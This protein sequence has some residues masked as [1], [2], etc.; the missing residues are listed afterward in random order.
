MR[1][2]ATKKF[3]LSIVDVRLWNTVTSCRIALPWLLRSEL[4]PRLQDPK[5]LINIQNHPHYFSL[6]RWIFSCIVF[7]DHLARIVLEY[8]SRKTVF[9]GIWVL[10]LKC[11]TAK[12]LLLFST[13][14]LRWFPVHE[15]AFSHK[16]LIRCYTIIIFHWGDI[17]LL[18][19]SQRRSAFFCSL[20]TPTAMCSQMG[21]QRG[22]CWRCMWRYYWWVFFWL[23]YFVVPGHLCW[24]VICQWSHSILK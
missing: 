12:F 16:Y 20:W 13:S 6:Y 11:F 1:E 10:M 17:K 14:Q 22:D 21:L 23:E 8:H 15:V 9:W 18:N 7:I 19:F 24:F 5:F 2:V 4:R 3:I